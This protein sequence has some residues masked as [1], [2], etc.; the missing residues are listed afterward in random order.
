MRY[1]IYKTTNL[2]NGKFYI[3]KHQTKRPMDSYLG[4][5]LALKKAISKYGRRNFKKEILFDFDN[6]SEMNQKEK[7]LIT[8]EFISRSDTYNKGIGGEGGPHFKGK[9]HSDAV[10]SRITKHLRKGGVKGSIPW[11]K[12]LR[13][14]SACSSV[15]VA[16]LS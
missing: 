5:G 11:N 4:S 14:K 13:F 12:G 1:T 9:K 6:E 3:G 16:G 10:K 2:L 8:E 7:E 15:E